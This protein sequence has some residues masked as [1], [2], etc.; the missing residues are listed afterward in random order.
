MLNHRGCHYA[1]DAICFHAGGPL[2]LGDIEDVDGNPC[3]KCPWH[4][5]LIKL[6]DGD[7][8]YDSLVKDPK[9]GKLVP[10]IIEKYDQE[11]K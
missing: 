9:T 2:T 4:H 10:H 3:I 11:M 6:D 5:Y 1:I 7:K 8:L